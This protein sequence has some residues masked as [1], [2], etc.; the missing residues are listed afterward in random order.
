MLS[1]DVSPIYYI[2]YDFYLNFIPV[3]CCRTRINARQVAV[4]CVAPNLLFYFSLCLAVGMTAVGAFL[5]KTGTLT[6][7]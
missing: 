3:K 4:I 2:F 7:S 5:C 6:I 1:D